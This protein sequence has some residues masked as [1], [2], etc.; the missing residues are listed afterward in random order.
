MIAVITYWLILTLATLVAS[1]T[2]LT[3]PPGPAPTVF[4]STTHQNGPTCPKTALVS[5]TT[6][7]AST[8]YIEN[9]YTYNVE[10]SFTANCNVSAAPDQAHCGL[11]GYWSYFWERKPYTAEMPQSV[12][13]SAPTYMGGGGATQTAFGTTTLGKWTLSFANFDACGCPIIMNWIGFATSDLTNSSHTAQLWN[14]GVVGGNKRGSPEAKRQGGCACQKQ[15]FCGTGAGY[16]TDNCHCPPPTRVNFPAPT[17]FPC[18]GCDGNTGDWKRGD[19]EERTGSPGNI[20]GV[21]I[22]AGACASGIPTLG[23]FNTTN[24]NPALAIAY[25]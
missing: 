4:L 1:Q 7:L 22:L 15:G 12:L 25:V 11:S 13:G 21:S 14:G 18:L 5:G 16:C 23:V 6:Y 19:L 3:N 10:A 9:G 24:T 20:F 17:G 2:I 8:S